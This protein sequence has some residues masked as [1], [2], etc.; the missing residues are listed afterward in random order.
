LID[1]DDADLDEND[2][3]D[4]DTPFNEDLNLELNQLTHSQRENIDRAY[5]Y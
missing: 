5:Y 1:A 3:V 2:E 4:D